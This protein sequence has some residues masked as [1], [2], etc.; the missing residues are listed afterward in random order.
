MAQKSPR[1]ILGPPD[2]LHARSNIR[3]GL[4][5]RLLGLHVRNLSVL[6]YSI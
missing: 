3:S 1:S 4:A 6:S 2:W 5:E